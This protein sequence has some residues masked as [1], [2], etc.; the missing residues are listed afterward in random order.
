MAAPP[1]TFGDPSPKLHENEYG[2]VPPVVDAVKLT[3]LPVVPVVGAAV[4]VTA[5][6]RGEMV[7]VE[8]ADCF[9]PF[10]SV[11]VTLTVKVPFASYV[12]DCV[13]GLV[14]PPS[15]LGVASPKFHE[16]E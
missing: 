15:T 5:S 14:V 11:I 2:A 7:I 13:L 16:N 3:G 9:A 6:A 1:E 4:K 12:W 10:A 8:V